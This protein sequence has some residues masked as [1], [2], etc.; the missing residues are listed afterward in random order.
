MHDYWVFAIAF[1][2]AGELMASGSLSFDG[3]VKVWKVSNG[4]LVNTPEQEKWEA[5]SLSFSP[6][7]R[8]LA[9]ESSYGTHIWPVDTWEMR[10]ELPST[11]VQFSPDS[12]FVAELGPDG[13][14]IWQLSDGTLVHTR[15]STGIVRFEFSPIGKWLALGM[16]DGSV[17]LWEP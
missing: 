13:L 11:S 1:S 14:Q 10:L 15:P 17:G 9:S 7:G 12:Q 4:Q 5:G 2:P 8:Y 16:E 6:D 3:T